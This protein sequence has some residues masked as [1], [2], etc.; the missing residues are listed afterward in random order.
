MFFDDLTTFFAYSASWERALSAQTP[1]DPYP[2][3]SEAWSLYKVFDI[4]R[5][6]A[7]A[8]RVDSCGYYKVW[9]LSNLTDKVRLYLSASAESASQPRSPKSHKA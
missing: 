1:L 2:R 9:A 7:Q 8:Q 3:F 4:R 5:P 6:S